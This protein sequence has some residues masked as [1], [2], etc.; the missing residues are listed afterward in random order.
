MSTNLIDNT[1]GENQEKVDIDANVSTDLNTDEKAP[2]R[3]FISPWWGIYIILI[4][5]C[6][7]FSLLTYHPEPEEYG[8][9]APF[10]LQT[11]NGENF[12]LGQND[13]PVIVNFIFTR[14]P[15]ICPLLTTKMASLQDRIKRNR[16]I[17]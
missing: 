16:A 2:A 3:P 17:G 7:L 8:I 15:N 14:C 4:I 9:V 6:P 1:S 10:V 12:M 5:G 11:Q 13:Q